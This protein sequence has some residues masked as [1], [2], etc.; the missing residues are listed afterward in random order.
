MSWILKLTGCAGRKENRRKMRKTKGRMDSIS[1]SQKPIC[2]DWALSSCLYPWY[3]VYPA[4]AM[5][6]VMK[7]NWSPGVR[8][9]KGGSEERWKQLQAQLLLLANEV[10]QH[11]GNNMW[12]LQNGCCSP[13]ALKTAQGSPFWPTLVPQFSFLGMTRNFFSVFF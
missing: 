8:N 12:E 11:I 10:S 4:E 3:Q 6:V 1:M 7:L 5:P 9:A 2:K 13:S